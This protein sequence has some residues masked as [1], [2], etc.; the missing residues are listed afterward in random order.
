M[1]HVV[2]KIPC[3]L[4]GVGSEGI[5]DKNYVVA[6]PVINMLAGNRQGLT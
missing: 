6:N 3:G 4:S 2:E 5:R 1:L